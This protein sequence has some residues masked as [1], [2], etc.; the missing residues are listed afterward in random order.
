VKEELLIFYVN[1]RIWLS[2]SSLA[3]RPGEGQCCESDALIY[4]KLPRDIAS[5]HVLL[6]DP[7]LG[8]GNTASRA[9]RVLLDKGVEESRIQ[10]LTLVASRQGIQHMMKRHAA[11]QIITTEIDNEIDANFRVKPGIGEFGDRYFCA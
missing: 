11:I 8:T 2:Y 7:V 3:C 5:R 6:M 10:L 9:V 1:E 4:E